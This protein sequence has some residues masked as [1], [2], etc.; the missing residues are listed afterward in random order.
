MDELTSEQMLRSQ[1]HGKRVSAGAGS[2]SDQLG[3]RQGYGCGGGFH[4]VKQGGQ[5]RLNLMGNK[6]FQ[7]VK[8][9]MSS[10][11]LII[12]YSVDIK[13]VIHIEVETLMS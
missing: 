12:A 9:L 5:T 6:A 4:S 7:S 8:G 2:I 13:L 10:S 1:E 11:L 3:R